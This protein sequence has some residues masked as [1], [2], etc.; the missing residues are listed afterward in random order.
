VTTP[1]AL[2]A[3]DQGMVTRT[4][5]IAYADYLV[6]T[7]LDEL[8]GELIA[9][10]L[11]YPEHPRIAEL[12]RELGINPQGTKEI[13]KESQVRRSYRMVM[14]RMS[15][16]LARWFTHLRVPAQFVR[17]PQICHEWEN[18]P[19][20]KLT[21]TG[22]RR[23][24]DF[25]DGRIRHCNDVTLELVGVGAPTLLGKLLRIE[26]WG[27]EYLRINIPQDYCQLIFERLRG[28]RDGWDDLK[29]VIEDNTVQL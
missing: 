16:P 29:G 3:D 4:S 8:A 10:Q 15:E 20:S 27:C 11:N 17:D 24:F 28:H 26:P 22:V 1:D 5:I 7:R 2:M 12:Y 14:G 19:I 9:L 18:N 13:V 21:L 25:S 6:E 23:D